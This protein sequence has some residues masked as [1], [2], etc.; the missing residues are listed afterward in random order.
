MGVN[1]VTFFS[2]IDLGWYHTVERAKLGF[3]FSIYSQ[4]ALSASILLPA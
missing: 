4:A 1:N 2:D 3:S